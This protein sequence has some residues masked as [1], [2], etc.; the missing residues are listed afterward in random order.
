MPTTDEGVAGDGSM[1]TPLLYQRVRIDGLA[2]KPEFNG[3]YGKCISWNEEKGRYGVALEGRKDRLSLKS[4]N[5]TAVSA[6]DGMKHRAGSASLPATEMGKEMSETQHAEL[7]AHLEAAVAAGRGGTAAA[8]EQEIQMLLQAAAADEHQ[9]M[10]WFNLAMAYKE[11][12]SKREAVE[13][14]DKAVFFTVESSRP[15]V[16][17]LSDP[18]MRRAFEEIQTQVVTSGAQLLDEAIVGRADDEL[19]VDESL[20][21]RLLVLA[22]GCSDRLDPLTRSHMHHVLGNIYRKRSKHAPAIDQLRKA[23]AA[24]SRNGRGERDLVS[25][26][27]VSE[28]LAAQAIALNPSWQPPQVA[29]AP[30]RSKMLEAV[31]ASRDALS[32]T[33]R[34]HAMRPSAQLSLARML[35]NLIMMS[36]D[37]K[38]DIGEASFDLL[39]EGRAMAFSAKE[40]A[41]GNDTRIYEMAKELLMPTQPLGQPNSLKRASLEAADPIDREW[42]TSPFRG[43]FT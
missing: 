41:E 34:E 25:L 18:Q 32:A 10:P 42:G 12:G 24:S 6:T 8:K 30:M 20:G 5:L 16:V 22:D 21:K 40:A 19:L 17:D 29:S 4:A 31:E 33:P 27:L 26:G 11:R 15:G 2:A 35:S 43:G 3:C 38:G 28:V 13:A 1:R 14:M 39:R 37:D 7:Q 9:P 36:V 23:D